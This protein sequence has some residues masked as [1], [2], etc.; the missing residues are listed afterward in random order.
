MRVITPD[1]LIKK[2]A[3]WLDSNKKIAFISTLIIG[4]ITNIILLTIMIMSSDGLWNSLVHFSTGYEITL[5]RWALMFFEKL[6]NNISMVTVTTVYSIFITAVTAVF[7]VD[8][9]GL[10]SK[11]S[12]FL[13]GMILGVSPCLA[14][15]M[16]YS[17]TSDLYCWAFLLSVISAWLICRNKRGLLEGLFSAIAIMV[18]MALYQSYIG[19]TVGLCIS[20]VILNSINSIKN[21]KEIFKDIG[22]RVLVVCIG[23]FFYYISV[24]VA[25]YHY[26]LKLSDYHGVNEVSFFNIIANLGTSIPTTYKVFFGFFYGDS[27]INNSSFNRGIL[28]GIFLLA[29]TIVYLYIIVNNKENNK[30]EKVFSVIFNTIIFIMLPI[31]LNVINVMVPNTTYYPL[32]SEQMLLIVPLGFA[33]LE[34]LEL[35]KASILKWASVLSCFIICITYYLSINA[36]YLLIRIK[37]NQAYSI[38]V[39]AVARLENTEG[40]AKDKRWIFTGVI[41]GEDINKISNLEKYTLNSIDTISIFHRD[42]YGAIATWTKLLEQY[43][44]ITP[45]F[46]T[47]DEYKEIINTEEYK[48]MPMFPEKDSIREINGIMVVK[49]ENELVVK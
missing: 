33:I 49:F 3:R 42:Y 22:Y 43:L 19:I 21:K 29:I 12:A 46:A 30:K 8:F 20:K 2:L 1:S 27:N 37:Y 47:I 34:S 13:T 5:G 35:E 24:K 23:L 10:Q 40:Y 9:Y 25:I 11:I 18:S 28:W 14:M 38:T 48:N 39:R 36:S 44:G 32:N 15:T 4:F 31:G 26:G 16:L 41:D 7:I 6:R 17:F 45:N